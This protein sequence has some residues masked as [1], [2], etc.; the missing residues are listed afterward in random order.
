MAKGKSK[1]IIRNA[2][3]KDVKEIHELS[4]KVYTEMP[5]DSM[6]VVRAQINNYPDGHFVAEY[7]GK[8]VGYCSTIRV[9]EKIALGKHT[10]RGAT[11]GGYGSTHDAK[12]DYLY[13]VDIFV[14]PDYRGLKIGE[15]FYKERKRLC[16]YHRLKG[17]VF[18][19]RMP[20]L[21]KRIKKIGSVEN[22][23]EQVKEKKIR[24]P[25]LT[26]QIRNG[27]EIIGILKNY[28][29]IDRKSLGYAAHMIW[30]NPD[31][32]ESAVSTGTPSTK[33]P[34]NVRVATVQ[35][36]QRKINS[37]EDFKTV[38]TY[39]VD[40]ASD[41]QCDFVVFPELFTM[42]L[43]SI[44][45]ESMPPHESMEKLTSYTNDLREL[46]SDTA[47]KYNVNIIAG[48]H[49]V[50]MDKNE[51][52]NICFICLRDG[53]V[54]EQP[55]IHVTPNEKY[56]WNVTGGNKVSA[57]DTDC[58]PIG[59]LICYDIQ[60]PEI[61]RHL[62]DQGANI[63]FVPYMTE[64]RHG[65]N[66]IRYCAQARAIENQC[67]VVMSGNVGN[68]PRVH[69]MDI[70]Y[71]QSCIITPCDFPFARDGIASDTTPNV[72]TIAIADIS[73]ENLF[74]ARNAGTVQNLKDR[75]HELYGIT[76]HKRY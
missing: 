42:Q 39:F 68:L 73:L 17:I 25:V 71:A 23:I 72:E 38:F 31:Y 6:D 34:Q 26:F 59:V 63:L 4:L 22:Y 74:H 66:R 32:V 7:E 21:S 8:I 75:R 36:H 54:H 64:E 76:W 19:G 28:L 51:I 29:P 58:G 27:F 55:K 2:S 69:N 49:P 41:Y 53:S 65:Y 16:K 11:G 35:Y 70:N 40:V 46:F 50:K 33:M 12:G 3:F 13:G 48:S 45:N 57:I 37:F 61:C 5:P 60:F 62:V 67:Y 1:L 47:I 43:L 56:W 44:E 10:W 20:L 15:R 9:P 30:K 24:D 52:Q 14:D 18:A